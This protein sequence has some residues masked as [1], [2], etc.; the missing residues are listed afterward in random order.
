MRAALS[1]NGYSLDTQMAAVI[2]FLEHELPELHTQ[3]IAKFPEAANLKWQEGSS[4]VDTEM[5]GVDQEWTSW[6]VDWIEDNTPVSWEDGEPWTCPV[7][8]HG[9]YNYKPTNIE[10]FGSIEE[11]MHAWWERFQSNGTTKVDGI[12]YPGWGDMRAD[13]AA[14][15]VDFTAMISAGQIAWFIHT[16]RLPTEQ[17]PLDY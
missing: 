13:D 15:I 9:G 11:A 14:I 6:V 1:S 8:M 12:L 4:W 17:P 7:T 10:Y 16:E 2:A 3:L 5:M